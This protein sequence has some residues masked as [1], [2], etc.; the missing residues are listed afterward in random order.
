MDFE[1]EGTLHE[2]MRIGQTAL[3]LDYSLI[4]NIEFEGIDYDDVPDF[5]DAFIASADYDGRP[6]TEKELETINDDRD[7]VY[8]RLTDYLF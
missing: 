1:K 8:D 6:M 3:Q 5:C 7:L 4:D 2:Q